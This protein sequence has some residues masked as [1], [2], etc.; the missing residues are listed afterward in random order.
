MGRKRRVR[1]LVVD[2]TE[3]RWCFGHRWDPVRGY[4]GSRST[5]TLWRPEGVARLRLV[6]RPTTDRHIADGFFDEGAAVRLPDRAYVNLHEPGNVRA[7]FEEAMARGLFPQSGQAEA[8][9]WP[10][11]DALRPQPAPAV[12]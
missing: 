5:V 4:P 6:F 8:D 11:F 3:Y 12:P 2:G 9:G 10:L 7:L 1:S